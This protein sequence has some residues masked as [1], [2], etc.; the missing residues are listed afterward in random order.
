MKKK[1]FLLF[2]SIIFPLF[3]QYS[4]EFICRSD[5]FQVGTDS[6]VYYFTLKNTGSLADTYAFDCVVIDSVPGWFET[7]CAAGQCAIPGMIIYEYLLPGEEDTM[8]DIRV[9]PAQ[10]AWGEEIICLKVFS[11]HNPSLRDS[12]NVYAVMEQGISEYERINSFYKFEVYPNPF[13]KYLTL[14]FEISNNSQFKISLSVYDILGKRVKNFGDLMI[15]DK[16]IKII[17]DAKDDTGN[18]LTNGAYFVKLKIGEFSEV[19][20]IIL[21]SE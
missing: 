21:W 1:I 15:S 16:Y 6:F 4:F 9:Y 20:K 14:K 3:A 18:K 19:K 7:Y 5:T 12:I 2:L 10:G 11:L 17:W 8:I 13:N